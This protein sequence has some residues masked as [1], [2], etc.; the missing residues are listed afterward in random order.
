MK[1]FLLAA[2]L[3]VGL[4]IGQAAQVEAQDVYVGT[5]EGGWKAYVMTESY[6]GTRSGDRN[7][8]MS[9]KV[10]TVSPKGRVTFK[11]STGASG[12]FYTDSV[13]QYKVESEIII[14]LWQ[15]DNKKSSSSGSSS[16]SSI[17]EKVYVGMND[18]GDTEVY[19]LP[20]TIRDITFKGYNGFSVQV[21]FSNGTSPRVP[22]YFVYKDG[23]WCQTLSL[24]NMSY[25]VP[26]SKSKILV[27]VVEVANRYR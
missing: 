3:I 26:I 7:S 1:K 8:E 11:D 5:W 25:P 22:W 19:I 24:D 9:C 17:P 14:V 15:L 18:Y 23:Q 12:T 6:R 21:W 2:A 4:V 13:G 20:K 10:K 27:K 16:G